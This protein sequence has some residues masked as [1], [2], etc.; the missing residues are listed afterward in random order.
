MKVV[1]LAAI[2]F[3]W[4]LPA[5]AQS[6]A[7]HAHGTPATKA[8]TAEMY[9]GQV[10]RVNKETRRVTLAHGP[11]TGFDMPAMTMAFPVKDPALL[12]NLKE[13]DKVRFTL[14]KSG[15][16]LVVTRIEPVK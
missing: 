3:T 1:S 14:E 6:A 13:G 10:R 16:N 5:L 15:E 4:A 8:A 2:A 12:T 9:D 7:T 11:L